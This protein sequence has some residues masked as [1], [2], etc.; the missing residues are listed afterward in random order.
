MA[1]DSVVLLKEDKRD[2]SGSKG[3]LKIIEN[4]EIPGYFDLSN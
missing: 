1:N 3:L 2:S 4:L